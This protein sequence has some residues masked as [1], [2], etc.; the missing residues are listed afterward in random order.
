M[1]IVKKGSAVI[2]IWT[3]V[4]QN[5][6]GFRKIS[7]PRT[8][9]LRNNQHKKRKSFSFV[10]WT[11]ATQAEV[12]NPSLPWPDRHESRTWGEPRSS[13]DYD[14]TNYGLD[15]LITTS[16]RVCKVSSGHIL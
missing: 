5:F 10:V 6:L 8:W 14:I 4:N 13:R 7:F 16:T 9:T 3:A 2:W 11:V 15:S 12:Q 1:S